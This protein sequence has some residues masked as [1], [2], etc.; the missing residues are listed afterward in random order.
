MS[1]IEDADDRH[2]AG[3][4]VDLVGDDGSTL[5]ADHVQ[6]LVEVATVSSLV[7]EGAQVALAEVDD[8][9]DLSSAG[10]W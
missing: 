1:A 4:V 7:G 8:A 9:G 5:V 2:H 10:G 6:L 3:L